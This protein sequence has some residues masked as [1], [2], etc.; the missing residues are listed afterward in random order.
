MQ[1]QEE[2]NDYRR[3]LVELQNESKKTDGQ[4]DKYK[5]ENIQLRK[6]NENL[7][8]SNGLFF[9]LNINATT[10]ISVSFV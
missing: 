7:K 10:K 1:V 5:R 8:V 9:T 6:E 2:A 4:S 3:Q